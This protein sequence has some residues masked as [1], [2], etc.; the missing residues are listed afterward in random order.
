MTDVIS[1]PSASVMTMES[2]KSPPPR[3]FLPR[4][5]E[6]ISKLR[7]AQPQGREVLALRHRLSFR[8]GESGSR[9]EALELQPRSQPSLPTFNA[10]L[11]HRYGCVCSLF[12]I[13]IKSPKCPLW[14]ISRHVRCNSVCPLYPR[15]RTGAVQ[16]GMSALCQIADMGAAVSLI[17]LP[18]TRVGRGS[19]ADSNGRDLYYLKRRFA[20][21]RAK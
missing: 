10:S 1:L 18:R 12:D 9:N 4:S 13:N 14:V 6:W 21:S 3:T 17:V 2:G 15:E 19:D 8:L 5:R 20:F 16:R 7:L 11:Q